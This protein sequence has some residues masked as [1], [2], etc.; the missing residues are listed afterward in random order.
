LRVFS[1]TLRNTVRATD[2]VSRH[3]GEEF[4]VVFPYASPD[5]AVAVIERVRMELVAA[6]SDGRTPM[7]T[8]SA[9]VADS[10]EAADSAAVLAIA[11]ERLL[12][13]KRA[14]R[15]RVVA[16]DTADLMIDPGRP[17]LQHG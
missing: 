10:A 3:G 9:G 11:D 16:A 13:A 7:F 1:R 14:G 12:A 17:A 4:V 15:N 6:L 8:M 5:A 2:I